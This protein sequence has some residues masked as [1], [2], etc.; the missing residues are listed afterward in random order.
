MAGFARVAGLAAVLAFGL[1]PGGAPI[2]F[3]QDENARVVIPDAPGGGAD[4]AGCYR[5]IGVI[6]GK[7]KM[8]FC[9]KGRGTYRVIGEKLDCTGRLDWDTE[10][11]GINIRL[12]RASCGNGKAWS[13]DTAWCRP[14]LILGMIGLITEDGH[15]SGLTCDYRPA[16]GTGVKPIVFGARR[17]S[18]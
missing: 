15:L 17:I 13:A 3:A 16:E 9:L 18:G 14:N 1:L 8:D 6:Y 2:A 12:R 4:V 11:P 5:S 7:Y 10:G